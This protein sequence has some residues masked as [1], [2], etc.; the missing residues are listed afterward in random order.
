MVTQERE[1]A[2]EFKP[3]RGRSGQIFGAVETKRGLEPLRWGEEIG[4]DV[5]GAQQSGKTRAFVLPSLL[6]EDIHDDATTWS[7]DNRRIFTYGYESVKII[8]D[9]KGE[10]WALTAGYR[11]SL[12]ENVY[13]I[14]PFSKDPG[15]AKCNPFD[16]IRVYGDDFFRDCRRYAAWLCEQ[17]AIEKPDYWQNTSIDGMAGFIGHNALRAI[18]EG[19][20]TINSP[21]GLIR[22]ISSFKTIRDAIAAV[23]EYDHD[24]HLLMGWFEEEDGKT[25]TRRT[26]TCPWITRVMTILGAKEADELSGIYGSIMQHL[27][28]FNDPVLASNSMTST[29]D[30]RQAMNDPEH[31]TAIYIRM[32][33]ADID[34]LRGYVRLLVN[35]L[36]YEML[37][38]TVTRAG[39]SARGNL[40]PFVMWLEECAALNRLEQLQRAAA[41]MRGMGGILITVFQNRNQIETVYG[42]KETITGNQGLHLRYTPETDDEAEALSKALGEYSFVVKERNVSGDRMTIAPRNHLAENNRIETRRWYTPFEVKALPKTKLFFFGKGKQGCIDQYPF[43]QVPELQRR[44]DLP[45]PERSDVSMKVPFCITNLEREL[46]PERFAIA[47][48]PA[49]DRYKKNREAAE[50]Q[51]NGSLVYRWERTWEDSGKT[52]FY[53]QVW[54]PNRKKPIFDQRKGYESHDMREE[55]IASALAA[56]DQRQGTDVIKDADTKEDAVAQAGLFDHLGSA[57]S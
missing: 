52:M 40:R 7:D 26:T 28:I 8:L 49:P 2:N 56:I 25:T 50:P 32:S 5:V 55:N 27:P 20:A 31:S 29:F 3:R 37:Q 6:I 57:S 53:A 45:P 16:F 51:K 47:I 12:G 18:V 43:D 54:L 46:G 15:V 10:L 23:L 44:A 36:L 34:Q 11:K 9:P 42:E 1:P 14:D 24:P 30:I 41:Y 21:S 13:C 39:R 19:D 35:Y 4:V 22:F 17:M 48:S 33:P 38:P